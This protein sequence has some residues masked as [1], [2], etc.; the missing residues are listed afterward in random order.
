[1]TDASPP[2]QRAVTVP[3]PPRQRQ[4]TLPGSTKQQGGAR[5]GLLVF[6]VVLIV[7]SVLGFWLIL[8]SVDQRQQVL[9]AARD[10]QRWDLAAPSDFVLVE[11]NVG[12]A[13]ALGQ[14]QL[15]AV[16]GRWASGNIP[17]G[18]IITAG[19]FQSPPLSSEDEANKVLIQVSLP[20]GEVPFGGMQTGDKLALFGREA[21]DADDGGAPFGLI[22]V[23]TLDFVLDGS[24][25]YIVTPEEA[26]AIQD[27]VGRFGRASD[28]RIW[29]LGFDLD[30]SALADLYDAPALPATLFED[31]G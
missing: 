3:N 26:R 15:D 13:S 17:A 6:G 27:M 4:V 10:I 9:V 2:Q 1:M 28:R 23:L 8:R 19:L 31:L 25:V 7:G 16:L 12:Q 29:K 11:A 24:L 5:I 22:G 18:T 21:S 14:H 30:M 20:A